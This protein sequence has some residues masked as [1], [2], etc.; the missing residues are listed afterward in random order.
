VG[1][2]ETG[3]VSLCERGQLV[4]WLTPEA[5]RAELARLMKQGASEAGYEAAPGGEMAA[6]GEETGA[7]GARS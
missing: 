7:E 2:E 3:A 6:G 1:S 5:L 4:R